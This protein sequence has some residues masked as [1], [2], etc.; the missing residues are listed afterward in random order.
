MLLAES[1]LDLVAVYKQQHKWRLLLR[2]SE[3]V[4]QN[5]N[6]LITA[7]IIIVINIVITG[8]VV[9]YYYYYPY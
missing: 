9:V 8:I 6:S 1:C 3:D 5:P 7:T 2:H 4:S